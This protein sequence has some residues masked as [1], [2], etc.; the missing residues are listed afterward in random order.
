MSSILEL[1]NF[2]RAGV[3]LQKG[4]SVVTSVSRLKGFHWS[5]R[6]VYRMIQLQELKRVA[7]LAK[8]TF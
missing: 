3:A 5:A 6:G 7:E 2:A 8:K 1:M 4:N